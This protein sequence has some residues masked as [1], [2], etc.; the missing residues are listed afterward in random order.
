METPKQMCSPLLFELLLL[1]VFD[2]KKCEKRIEI[3]SDEGKV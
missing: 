1:V 2:N 3:T